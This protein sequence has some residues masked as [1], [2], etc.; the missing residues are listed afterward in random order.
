MQIYMS[1]RVCISRRGRF[2]GVCIGPYEAMEDYPKL[3]LGLYRPHVGWYGVWSM[4]IIY[5]HARASH[6]SHV[7]VCVSRSLCMYKY[8]YI[9][10]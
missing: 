6:I 7:Y 3:V 1:V 8:R 4:H 5:V 2:I 9:H 10:I